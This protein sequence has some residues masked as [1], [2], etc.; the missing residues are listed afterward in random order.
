MIPTTTGATTY[1]ASQL[2][3]CI[4]PCDAYMLEMGFLCA[5]WLAGILMYRFGAL[6]KARR[7]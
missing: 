2:C 7:G 6:W 4:Y 5:G 1:A 3:N